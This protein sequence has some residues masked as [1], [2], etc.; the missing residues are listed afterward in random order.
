[1]PLEDTYLLEGLLQGPLPSRPGAADALAQLAA[2]H[3][4]FSLQTDGGQFSLLADEKSHDSRA[5]LPLTMSATVRESLEKVLELLTPPERMQVFSTLRSR[6]YR[7]GMEQQT[8]YL[9]AAPGIIQIQTRD[10]TADVQLRPRPATRKEKILLATG[11]AGI[12]ALVLALSTLFVDYRSLF[13]RAVT[14]IRGTRLDDIKLDAKA[15]EGFFKVEAT[16]LNAGQDTLILT[17]TRGPRWKDALQAPPTA[18][19]WPTALAAAALHRR[20][21]MITIQNQDGQL[22]RSTVLPLDGLLAAETTTFG[23]E[24]GRGQVVTTVAVLP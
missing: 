4:H 19:D 18:T 23:V 8:V 7:P 2:R 21:A 17:L 9:I 22:I 5:F 24:F 6:E 3:P 16:A 11:A 1:M 13:G 12:L 20:Y 14:N 15:F 10:T